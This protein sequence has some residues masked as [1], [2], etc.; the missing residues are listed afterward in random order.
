[1]MHSPVSHDVKIAKMDPVTKP[2]SRKKEG[3]R[4]TPMPNMD[5]TMWPRARGTDV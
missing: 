1:M 4:K 2:P 3:M 5:L